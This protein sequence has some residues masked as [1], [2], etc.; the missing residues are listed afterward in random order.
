MLGLA[1]GCIGLAVGC[2]GLAVVALVIK[3][4]KHPMFVECSISRMGLVLGLRTVHA[5]IGR[6]FEFRPRLIFSSTFFLLYNED[7]SLLSP[8]PSAY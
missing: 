8:E 2:T 1:V 5:C 3:G 7:K 4:F 6:G